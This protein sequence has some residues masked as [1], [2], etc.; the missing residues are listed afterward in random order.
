MGAP[1]LPLVVSAR[2]TQQHS[3][4]L[5]DLSSDS[6][7]RKSV[8]FSVFFLVVGVFVRVEWISGG[9]CLSP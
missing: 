7:S 8:N 3:V 9:H 6:C 4:C 5:E 1:G 2:E